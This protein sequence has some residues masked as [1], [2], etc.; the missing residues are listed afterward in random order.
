MPAG[1]PRA[2]ILRTLAAVVAKAKGPR[3]AAALYHEALD[4]AGA[5]ARLEAE[6]HREL[7]DVLRFETGL[8][9][10]EPHAAAAVRAAERSG[11]SEELCRALSCSASC[12]SSSDTGSTRM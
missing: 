5:D 10:A 6:I 1:Q 4:E 11:E 7:A 2:T 8:R 3:D 12:A 9:A